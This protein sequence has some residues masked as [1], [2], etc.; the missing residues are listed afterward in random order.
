MPMSGNNTVEA[1]T[2]DMTIPVPPGVKRYLVL[3]NPGWNTQW[4][5]AKFPT[6]ADITFATPPDTEYGFW[7]AIYPY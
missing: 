1:G 4:S 6:Y 2:T 5:I 3:V 7:W